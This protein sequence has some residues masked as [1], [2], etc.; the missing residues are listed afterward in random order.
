M[1][2]RKL[3]SRLRSCLTEAYIFGGARTLSKLMLLAGEALHLMAQYLPDIG[4][5]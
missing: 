1:L 5:K 3:G 4:P 2:G